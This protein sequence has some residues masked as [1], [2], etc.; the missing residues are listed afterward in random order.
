MQ[1][2][3]DDRFEVAMRTHRSMAR[4]RFDT[5]RSPREGLYDSVERGTTPISNRHTRIGKIYPSGRGNMGGR[6]V[7]ST[8]T[9]A[10]LLN[11]NFIYACHDLSMVF[12]LHLCYRQ[13]YPLQAI[14]AQ[15]MTPNINT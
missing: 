10:A 1:K 6:I 5:T 9:Q 7:H 14:V 8:F 13:R 12:N 2:D 3:A 11:I 4:A 15:G